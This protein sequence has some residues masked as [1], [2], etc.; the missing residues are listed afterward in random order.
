MSRLPACTPAEVERA[1]RRAGFV[2]DHTKGSHRY[3]RH[4]DRPG[5]VTIAFHAKTLK[6]G[7]LMAIVKHAG[8]TP[9]EFR[10]LL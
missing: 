10:K 6:R 3:Y 2:L 1:L 4:P 9:D 8:F 7:T 5:L